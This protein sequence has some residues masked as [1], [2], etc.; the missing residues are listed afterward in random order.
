MF[1]ADVCTRNEAEE[2]P[3][4]WELLVCSQLGRK[5]RVDIY[6]EQ[7]LYVDGSQKE[8]EAVHF[9]LL[10]CF[11]FVF[12]KVTIK[13]CNF[14]FSAVRDMQQMYELWLQLTN[15]S[16]RTESSAV[17]PPPDDKQV[18]ITAD[19]TDGMVSGREPG[20]LLNKTSSLMCE[21]QRAAE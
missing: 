15:Q 20:L 21:G 1:S 4:Y 19:Y 9:C 7:Q 13:V 14:S 6:E 2:V 8:N 10:S 18:N 3:L 17:T 5:G 12:F 16:R 11:F